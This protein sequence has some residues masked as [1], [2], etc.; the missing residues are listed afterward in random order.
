MTQREVLEAWLDGRTCDSEG[1]RTDGY[2]LWSRGEEQWPIGH[3][4]GLTGR[5]S[6]VK[7]DTLMSRAWQV[8][9][10]KAMAYWR[11]CYPSAKQVDRSG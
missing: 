5:K 7:R 6:I 8:R 11:A 10:S 4:D 9:W 3:T 2:T 1:T